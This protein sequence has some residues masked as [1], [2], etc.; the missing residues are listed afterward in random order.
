ME[1]REDAQVWGNTDI[2][3]YSHKTKQE[4]APAWGSAWILKPI[5]WAM[6]KNTAIILIF[7]SFFNMSKQLLAPGVLSAECV[8]V[9]VM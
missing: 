1:I 5:S 6:K 4:C 3:T 8:Q 7:H 2:Q 9:S